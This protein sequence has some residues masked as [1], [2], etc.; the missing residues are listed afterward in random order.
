MALIL[1]ETDV[2]EVLS[3]REAIRLVEQAFAL[4]SDGRAALPPRIAL[5]LSGEAGAFRVMA[6][7]LPEMGAFGL[8]TL[9]GIPGKRRIG[10]TYF[11]M[12]LF[13]SVTGAFT[14]ML[15]ATHI[16]GVRTGAAGG[17]AAKYLAKPDA[18][19]LGVFGVGVQGR[20]QIEAIRAVRPIE[21]VKVFDLDLERA[22]AVAHMLEAGGVSARVASDAREVVLGSDIVVSATTATEPVVLG[23]WL[24]PGVHVNAIGANSPTKRELDRVALQ[25]ARLVL[26]F[27]EQ[28]LIEAGDLIEALEAGD[29]APSA[30][31]LELGDI[32]TGKQPGRRSPEEVTVF[33]SVG[34]AFQ[35]VAVAA[36]VYQ[37]ARERGLGTT[38][39]LER[40]G[41]EA[42]QFSR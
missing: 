4:H 25:K 28:V 18:R 12:L 19:V 38:I 20:A 40:V 33:K 5:K 16:T 6:A 2:A 36:W 39:D 29:I 11:V 10:S 21:T 14:A 13:D 9:S 31:E 35:D 42:V 34:V 17:V 7:S 23:Q 22:G 37:Q 24:E 3:M 30:V 1:T 32:I 8:K 41:H 26:D 15:P 27:R